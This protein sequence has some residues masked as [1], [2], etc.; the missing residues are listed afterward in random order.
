MPGQST[1][2]GLLYA[3]SSDGLAF[4]KPTLGRVEWNGSKSNNIVQRHMRCGTVM[5]DSSHVAQTN[6][7]RYRLFGRISDGSTTA[8]PGDY[9]W[10]P[11]SPG[12]SSSDDPTQFLPVRQPSLAN[13]TAPLNYDTMNTL[14]W[15]DQLQT[16]IAFSRISPTAGDRAIGVSRSRDLR[17]WTHGQLVL[18]GSTRCTSCASCLFQCGK[19]A[20]TC[21]PPYNAYSMVG[22]PWRT[23]F[24][25]FVSIFGN[26]MCHPG[27]RCQTVKPL[28]AWSED[29]HRWR[30]LSEQPVIPLGRAPDAFDSHIIFPAP[31]IEPVPGTLR[32]YYGA[33]DGPHTQCGGPVLKKDQ[34]RRGYVGVAHAVPDR[35]AGLTPSRPV[36][37]TVTTHALQIPATGGSGIHLGVSAVVGTSG[38]TIRVGVAGETALSLSQATPISSSGSAIPCAWADQTEAKTALAALRARNDSIKLQLQLQGN[39][40][41]YLVGFLNGTHGTANQSDP[42]AA[43]ANFSVVSTAVP[44][45][46]D[47]GDT[48]KPAGRLLVFGLPTGYNDGAWN[49]TAKSSGVLIGSVSSVST[50]A[51]GVND[52]GVPIDISLKSL[53]LGPSVVEVTASCDDGARALRAKTVVTLARKADSGTVFLNR[54]RG[55]GLFVG[56]RGLPYVPFGAYIGGASSEINRRFPLQEAPEGLNLAAP[57]ISKETNHSAAEWAAIIAFLDNCSAVGLQVHYHLN[58]V[59][60]MPDVP[61]KWSVLRT[62]ILRVRSHPAVFGWYIAGP[63]NLQRIMHLA[64]ISSLF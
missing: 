20:E 63:P 62:E 28:L 19:C 22:F 45:F 8:D 43:S 51:G 25:A 29:S 11:G 21:G 57:Y 52:G 58:S 30:I 2:Q 23:G 6:G 32:I 16:Y 34:C 5:H 56:E 37:V 36:A 12:L 59:G 31:P 18:N 49:L 10:N 33:G 54:K 40:T 60:V 47:I 35:W 53:S 26:P 17:K 3:R 61:A 42:V 13:E 27:E 55:P 1:E 14:M 39:V 46:Q 24:L 64:F 50:S 38:G 4:E 41:V 9:W 7:K 15:S 44:F 48:H